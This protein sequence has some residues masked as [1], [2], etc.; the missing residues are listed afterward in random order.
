MNEHVEKNA[1]LRR[2]PARMFAVLGPLLLALAAIGIYAVVEGQIVRETLGV[3][4]AGALAGWLVAMLVD[5]H[6]AH[7]VLYLPVFVGVP[8][9]LLLVATVACWLSAYRAGKIDPMA[10][11]RQQ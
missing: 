11:L 3:V 9:I 4:S 1:F 2:I 5:M 8:A 10:A 7:G 6:L